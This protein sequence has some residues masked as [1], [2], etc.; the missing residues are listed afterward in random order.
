MQSFKD[1]HRFVVDYPKLTMSKITVMISHFEVVQ[2]FEEHVI[3]CILV[4]VRGLNYS[5]PNL[6]LFP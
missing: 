2:F 5:G 4:I 6:S 1:T 3:Y